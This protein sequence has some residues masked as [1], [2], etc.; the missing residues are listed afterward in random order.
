MVFPPEGEKR[1]DQPKQVEKGNLPWSP[2]SLVPQVWFA[3][4]DGEGGMGVGKGPSFSEL[5]GR[6]SLGEVEP[7]V[8]MGEEERL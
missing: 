5:T 4:T 6:L 2:S 7:T 3:C 1:G 8:H